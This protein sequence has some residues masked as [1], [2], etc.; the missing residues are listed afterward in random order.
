[1]GYFSIFNLYINGSGPG[2]SP[3][4]SLVFA[5]TQTRPYNLSGRTRYPQVEYKFP[6]LHI[7]SFCIEYFIDLLHC[8]LI[9]FTYGH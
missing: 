8:I 5:K 1:M 4:S 9:I 2:P 3:D 6:S 7:L